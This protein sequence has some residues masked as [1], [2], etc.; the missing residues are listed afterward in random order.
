MLLALAVTSNNAS[1]RRLGGAGQDPLS[2][3]ERGLIEVGLD[4]LRRDVMVDADDGPPEPVVPSFDRVQVHVATDELLGRMVHGLVAV[5]RHAERRE[6][7]SLVGQQ[8]CLWL[9][10]RLQGRGEVLG[11]AA[12]H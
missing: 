8:P 10:Q 9:D 11:G 4:V 7:R 3:T 1:I 5:A 12:S 2:P 6:G